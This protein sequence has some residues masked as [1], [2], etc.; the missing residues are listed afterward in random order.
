[1][2]GNVSDSLKKKKARVGCGGTTLKFKHLNK[3]I[4]NESCML[5]TE[6][7]SYSSFFYLPMWNSL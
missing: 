3:E 6:S 5:T 4:V 7:V 2:Y 1:M